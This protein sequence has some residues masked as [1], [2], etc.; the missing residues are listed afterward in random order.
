MC[1]NCHN[2]VDAL[3]EA[4][5]TAETLDKERGKRL[6]DMDRDELDL[7]HECAVFKEVLV[8]RAEQIALLKELGLLR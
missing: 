7:A 5:R 6:S 8:K 2:N 4:S 3:K 1:G